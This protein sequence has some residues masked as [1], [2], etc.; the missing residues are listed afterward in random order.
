MAS[1]TC[2]DDVGSFPSMLSIKTLFLF[3]SGNVLFH[4]MLFYDLDMYD[5]FDVHSII[6]NTN[7]RASWWKT[8][9]SFKYIISNKGMI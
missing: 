2:W 4:G 6:D 3:L 8:N 9:I 7:G 5:M 1:K